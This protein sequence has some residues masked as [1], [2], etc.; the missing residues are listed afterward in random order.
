MALETDKTIGVLE[1]L[2]TF[3]IVIN[4][5]FSNYGMELDWFYLKNRLKV[6]PEKFVVCDTYF[7]HN[8]FRF[9]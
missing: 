6:K 2:E 8:I 1:P 7:N 3:I 4:S 5:Q 9:G